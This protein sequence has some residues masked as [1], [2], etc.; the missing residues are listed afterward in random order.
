M[1]PCSFFLPIQERKKQRRSAADGKR[2]ER[3]KSAAAMGGQGGPGAAGG[4]AAAGADPVYEIFKCLTC[5]L[6]KG[7]YKTT[8]VNE[9]KRTCR[10]LLAARQQFNQERDA[11][12]R[13]EA[14]GPRRGPATIKIW[15]GVFAMRE[16]NRYDQALMG[17]FCIRISCFAF[18]F[19]CTVLSE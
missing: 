12:R 6:K 18:C 5:T 9:H 15:K 19:C 11:Q 8:F 13:K 4:G 7:L 3:K 10:K 16:T 14:A 17:H 1:I 2:S